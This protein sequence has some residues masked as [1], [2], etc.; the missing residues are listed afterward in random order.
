MSLV[1]NVNEVLTVKD[2]L[3]EYQK[4]NMTDF[5]EKLSYSINSPITGKDTLLD[6]YSELQSPSLMSSDNILTDLLENVN[7]L[8]FVPLKIKVNIVNNEVMLFINGNI[9]IISKS[10]YDLIITNDDSYSIHIDSVNTN[11]V[12]TDN[13]ESNCINSECYY[14]HT[15]LYRLFKLNVNII[16]ILT[17]DLDYTQD[18]VYIHTEIPLINLNDFLN[19]ITGKESYIVNKHTRTDTWV[20]KS[21]FDNLFTKDMVKIKNNRIR[22]FVWFI[23]E[24]CNG[25]DTTKDYI[26]KDCFSM[27][28]NKLSTEWSNIKASELSEDFPELVNISDFTNIELIK[29]TVIGLKGTLNINTNTTSVLLNNQ[30]EKLKND[31]LTIGS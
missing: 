23:R 31:L 28:N 1:L 18:L 8:Q 27:I 16:D 2:L 9:Y 5:I 12:F 7:V 29:V 20:T 14:L 4:G 24:Y 22:K 21:L 19:S 25:R 11:N 10:D 17:L 15:R 26:L 13:D 3:A 30:L 6:T